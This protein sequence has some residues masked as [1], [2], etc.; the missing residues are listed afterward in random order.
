MPKR[1]KSVHPD[2]K[3]ENLYIE[4][5]ANT[6]GMAWATEQILQDCLGRLDSKNLVLVD[7]MSHKTEA[8]PPS[9]AFLS[10]L[11]P[12][13][14]SEDVIAN[15]NELFTT[16]WV[17]RHGPKTARRIWMTQAAQLIFLQWTAPVMTLI[18]KLRGL[19]RLL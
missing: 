17:P 3:W 9:S 2:L 11:L 13:A 1:N 12:T 5:K 16:T 8:K 6:R 19:L 15:L 7:F 4:V 18:D 14:H 10:E